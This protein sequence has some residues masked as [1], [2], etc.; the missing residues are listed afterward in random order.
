MGSVSR[1]DSKP[2]AVCIAY[3]AQGHITPMLKLAKLLHNKGFHITFVNT[4][5][6]HRR[7]LRSRGPDSLKGL[8]SFR[9]ETIP[10]G[11]PQDP[12]DHADVT[13]DVRSLCESTRTTC[14]P[15]FKKLISK[16]NSD[17]GVPPVTCIV[18]DSIM[19]FSADA[20]E[21]FGIPLVMFW[22]ASACGFVCYMHYHKLVQKGLIP[23]KDMSYVTNGYLETTLDWV[24][25]IKEIRLRDMPSFLRTTDLKDIML[26]FF[27]GECARAHKASAIVMN[28]FDALEHDVLEACSSIHNMPPIYPIGPLN[29]QL[30]HFNNEHLNKIS[31]NLW[32]EDLECLEWLDKQEPNSV[33]YVNFG[34]ITTMTN[35]N[36]I[37]FAW[38]LAN[39]NKKFFWV[40]RPDL[41]AGEIAVLPPE[42]V[43]VTKIRG[44]LA[45]WC[46]QEQVLAHPSIGV[47]LTHSGWNSTLESVCG[48]VPMICWPFFAEQQTNCRFCNK[49][50]GNGL[51]IEHVSREKIESLV[52]ESMDGEKGQDMRQNALQWKK[53]AKDAA[54]APHGSSFQ[55]LE[56]VLHQVLL[57][58]F[59]TT[60]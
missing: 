9:F 2:H 10:D 23:F 5:Y 34:S 18:S 53:L 54:S 44:M 3:P 22:T 50:W 42:F 37:E 46:P 55:N 57:N 26:D 60:K 6:N 41:V 8:P 49:E 36:L 7:F 14:S 11:L 16:L 45:N 13:Q 24:P 12:D 25:G 51:E 15:H 31:S 28:T 47:F 29:F 32:R 56:N 33:V 1:I 38:G 30:N 19:S 4:E 58:N 52:R 40:I 35:E 43:E 21:E 20:A 59:T 27:I 48:G 17:G 39:S